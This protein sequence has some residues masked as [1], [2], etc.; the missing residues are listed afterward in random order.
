MLP[1]QEKIKKSSS[2]QQLDLVDSLSEDKKLRRKRIYIII[3]LIL[4][5]GLSLF[6][7]I[8]RSSKSFFITNKISNVKPNFSF[9]KINFPANQPDLEKTVNQIISTDKNTWSIFVQTTSLNKSPFSWS[10]NI[11]T[12]TSTTLNVPI[13]TNSILKNNLPEGAQIQENVLSNTDSYQLTTLITV[14]NKQLFIIIKVAGTNNLQSSI[15]LI[16]YLVEKIYWEL[17]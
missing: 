3:T 12:P 13:S 16:P 7:W 14:P 17:I 8:Y 4:T 11:E 10:K 1:K 9:P 2:S 15:K 5:V 6:F